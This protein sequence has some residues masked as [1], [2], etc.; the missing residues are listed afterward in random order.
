MTVKEDQVS[1]KAME[2]PTLV[3]GATQS[4]S[5]KTTLACGILAALRQRGIAVRPFKVGPDYIDPSHLARAA[6]CPCYNLDPWMT[7]T[8]GTL[9]SFARGACGG[10]LA[11]IEG[12]MGLFDGVAGGLGST[13]QIAK[14]FRAPVLLVLNAQGVGQSL[15]AQVE[16]FLNFD[17][18]VRYLGAVVTNVA[19]PR[20]ER[21]L[22][23]AFSWTGLKC[24]GFLPRL[25]DLGLPKRHLGLFTAGE[26]RR[27][28]Y[29]KLGRLVAENVNLDEIRA[30]AR[31]VAFPPPPVRPKSSKASIAVAR[32]EAFCFYYQENLDL[33][34]EAGASLIFFSPLK[35]DLPEAQGYYFGGGYPELF[36]AQLAKRESL[37]KALKEAYRRGKPILAECG[38]FMFLN[39]QLIVEEKAFRLSGL[40]PG[41]VEMTNRLKAL[42]YRKLLPR[43]P[44]FLSPAPLRGHEFRYSTLKEPMQYGFEAVDAWGKEVS[45]FGVVREN[46]FASYVHVHLGSFP[47]A[48]ENFVAQAAACQL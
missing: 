48:A 29:E 15:A 43:V 2:I 42:G 9:R 45:T 24:L 40:L 47:K 13:A 26:I 8:L 3:I 18:T 19:S 44:N 33:L 14:L 23:E 27:S 30:G 20:Q 16:G 46:L 6:E 36:A 21:M 41:K 5:G 1:L 25:K 4:G 31:K 28:F 10:E 7:G 39:Q 32:D 11:V 22:E 17:P 35:E 12:V 34:K 37:F 38:G